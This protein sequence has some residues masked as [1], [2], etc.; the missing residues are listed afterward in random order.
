MDRIVI[1]IDQFL[2]TR[3]DADRIRLLDAGCGDFPL[4]YAPTSAEVS[5]QTVGIDI[6]TKESPGGK[7]LSHFIAA[8]METLP[9]KN[10]AFDIVVSLWAME[11]VE[12]PNIAI[13]ELVR[14][15][16][17]GNGM[18]NEEMNSYTDKQIFRHKKLVKIKK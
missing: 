5:L 6:E 16:R 17:P 18:M 3:S 10:A 12:H 11:H 13:E 8:N 2:A 15:L 1:R 4:N 14:V 9:F 7:S